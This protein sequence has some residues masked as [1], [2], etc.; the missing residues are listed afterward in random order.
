M[1]D[2]IIFMEIV[3]FNEYA[4]KYT[5]RNTPTH[6][7]HNGGRKFFFLSVEEKLLLCCGMSVV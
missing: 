5:V 6:L 2:D 1:K 7:I 3:F 4:L